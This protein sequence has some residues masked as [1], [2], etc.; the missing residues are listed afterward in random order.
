MVRSKLVNI[1]ANRKSLPFS[2]RGIEFCGPTYAKKHPD[3]YFLYTSGEDCP[4]GPK[5]PWDHVFNTKFG[6]GMAAYYELTTLR[7]AFSKPIHFITSPCDQMLPWELTEYLAQMLGPNTSVHFMAGDDG[8]LGHNACWEA[9]QK[10]NAHL[11]EFLEGVVDVHAPVK[12][13]EKKPRP[14]PTRSAK[15]HAT[16]L[17]VGLG[18]GAV[19]GFV[20]ARL[21]KK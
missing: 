4:V 1:P 17:A 5:R 16:Y 15:P 8:K 3:K 2:E 10:Y 20:L 19:F 12:L 14:K 11:L 13:L 6:G 9:P 18:V 21:F 7:Q